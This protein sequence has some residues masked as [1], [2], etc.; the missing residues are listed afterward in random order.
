VQQVGQ[1]AAVGRCQV[2]RDERAVGLAIGR[3]ARLVRPV[4]RERAVR[5]C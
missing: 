2:E 3:D 1:L 4:E 5:R